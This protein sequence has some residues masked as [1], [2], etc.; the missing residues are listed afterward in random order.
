MAHYRRRTPPPLAAARVA[1]ILATWALAGCGGGRNPSAPGANS[2]RQTVRTA[3]LSVSGLITA[4]DADSIHTAL[5][6]VSGVRDV[7]VSVEEA[8]VT[9]IY[10][11]AKTTPQALVDAV[12][13]APGLSQY[14]ATLKE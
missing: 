7:Q 11:P 3:R 14:T 9:V 2:G 6:R 8:L 13:R 5:A 1:F 12:S 4:G 10:D